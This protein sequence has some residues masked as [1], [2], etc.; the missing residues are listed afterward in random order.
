MNYIIEPE[1]QI[2]VIAM[3]D[4]VVVGGGLTGVLAAVAAARA[5]AS[6]SLLERGGFLGGAGTMS[7]PIQGYVDCNGVQIVRGLAQEFYDRL[8]AYKGAYPKFIPCEMHNPFLIIDPEMVKLVCLEMVLEAGVDLHLHTWSVAVQHDQGRLQAVIVENKSGR[9]AVS[10]KI[11]IDCTGDGDIAA[12]AGAP[13][14]VGRPE[15]SI[16]QSATL[17]FRLDNV[18]TEALRQRLVEFPEK[19]D[20]YM[21][22]PQQ[23]RVNRDRFIVSGLKNLVDQARADGYEGVPVEMVNFCTLLDDG[24]VNINMTKVHR[25]RGHDAAELTRAEVESRLQVP[26]IVEFLR[27]YVPGF[28]NARL[29]L[30]PAIVGIRETRHILGDYILDTEDVVE[31]RRPHDTIA[32]GGYP[33]DIH[34]PRGEVRLTK[35]PP[36]GIPYRCLVPQKLENVLVAG[37]NFSAT[38]K[39]LASARVMATCMAMGQAA[40]EAGAW[41]AREECGTR[42]VDVPDLQ[43]R[44]RANGA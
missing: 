14:T 21:M 19:Y 7:L 16:P 36:Y 27:R 35:V 11:F 12:W 2:P 4:V 40:G 38:H 5:G 22:P 9:Q 43:S 13:F 31:G 28:Q 26:V 25:V 37:R 30:T 10:G 34:N 29:T 32:V 33:I 41:A 1:R 8:L 24:A 17:T 44:L 23:F 3:K 42:Q 18:D 6:V 39:A 15:D 20:L